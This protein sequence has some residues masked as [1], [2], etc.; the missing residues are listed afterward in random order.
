MEKEITWDEATQSSNFVALDSDEQKVLKLTNWR[1]E[2]R[3]SDAKI[4]ANEIE[5]S[6][7]VVEEDGEKVTDKI[8][9][10]LSKRLKVKFRPIFENRDRSDVIKLSIL[11]I[12]EQFNTQYSVKELKD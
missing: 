5:F 6:A 8:F 11:R 1:F 4:G 9:S 10:T 3:P 12:G 2:K 7:D